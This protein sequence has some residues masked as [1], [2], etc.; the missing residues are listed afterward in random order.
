MWQTDCVY[1]RLTT[2]ATGW[3]PIC[4]HTRHQMHTVPPQSLSNIKKN[5]H[6]FR[7]RD[8]IYR[9]SQ[10]QKEF[11]NQHISIEYLKH[12]GWSKSLCVPDDYNTEI[13][14]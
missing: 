13:Y 1:I 10:I 11:K 6:M 14:K 9:E 2:T 5:C 8:A 7:R 4:S 3:Q 12:A